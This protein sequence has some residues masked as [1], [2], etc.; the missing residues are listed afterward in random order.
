MTSHDT[1]MEL[2]KDKALLE[3]IS[4]KFNELTADIQEVM[5]ASDNP[6]VIAVLLFKLAEERD[7]TNKLLEKLNEKYDDIMFRIKTGG[8]E[9]H[10]SP[11][12]GDPEIL[13]DN[14]KQIM[15][16]ITKNGKATANDIQKA[17]NYKAQNGASQR[18]NKLCKENYLS[19]VRAGKKVLYFIKS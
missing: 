13:P 17:L 10:E 15:D 19:K 8:V 12:R 5:S 1:L 7:R 6:L 14:D 11:Y 3:K 9:N 2:I 4:P 18:L 16:Y